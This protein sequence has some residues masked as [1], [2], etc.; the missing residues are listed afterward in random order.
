MD[1]LRVSPG[2]CRASQLVV[3]TDPQ[4][5]PAGHAPSGARALP[6]SG[7]AGDHD[8]T[9]G[10]ARAMLLSLEGH[11]YGTVKTHLQHLATAAA[12]NVVRIG[13]WLVGTPHAPTRCSPYARLKEA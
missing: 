11:C 2:A 10:S 8:H 3:Y 5:D 7:Y 4:R 6:H 1:R 13:E 9:T 12:L